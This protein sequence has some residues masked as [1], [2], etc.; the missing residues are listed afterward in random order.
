MIKLK[1][2]SF[3]PL[4]EFSILL[5]PRGKVGKGVKMK[6]RVNSINFGHKDRNSFIRE[7]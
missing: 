3:M 7:L 4:G 1:S 6:K 5:P 2:C